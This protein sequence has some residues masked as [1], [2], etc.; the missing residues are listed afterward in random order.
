MKVAEIM[1]RHPVC[2]TEDDNLVEVARMMKEHDCGAIPVVEDQATLV[3]VG[4]ITDRDIVV[5]ALAADLDP[6]STKVEECMTRSLVTVQAEENVEE[7]VRL[8]EQHQLRRILVVDERGAVAGI[9]VQAQIAMNVNP[10]MAGEMIE[11]ISQ[12]NRNT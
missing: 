6:M 11:D 9:V 7:C 3:P 5:R 12:P 2:C 4:I 8:M 1:E 10:T